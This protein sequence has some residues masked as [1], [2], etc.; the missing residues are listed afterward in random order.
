[1]K[2]ESATIKCSLLKIEA[3]IYEM[4]HGETGFPRL[5]W[6]GSDGEYNI[7]VME[8][9][10]PSIESLLQVSKGGLSLSTCLML[11]EQMVQTLLMC[12]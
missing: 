4:F 5:Y 9:L 1:M 8:L 3:A 7:L 6:H 12:S 11:T 2:L 10:G